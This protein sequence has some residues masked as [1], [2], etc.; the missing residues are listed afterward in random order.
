MAPW[1]VF[2]AA[3]AVIGILVGLFGVG[4]SSIATPL[5]SVLGVPGLLAVASPL[6]ATIPAALA[7]AVPYLRGR[8]ARPRAAAW[9]LA[10]GIPAT[11]AGALLSTVVGGPALLIASGVVLMI[12]GQRVIRPIDETTLQ[13]GT[14]R[15]HNRPLL[16]AVMAAAGLFTGL[17]ANGGGFL[18][19]PIY[20]LVFGLDMR[21]AAG[22]SLLVI[23][24]LTVPTLATH[25]ALGHIDWAVAG[26]FALGAVPASAASGRLAHHVT[27]TTLRQGFGWF[28]VACGIAFVVYRLIGT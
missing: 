19:V 27:A 17:L 11:V 1:P 10:G 22:T 21:E 20:L 16:V 9:S 5:L 25:W 18:L 14:T 26:A 8:E 2:V 7:A 3:G 13:A 12:V 4:G 28:L 23:A 24:V 6:P 15:R